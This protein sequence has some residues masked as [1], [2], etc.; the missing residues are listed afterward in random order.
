MAAPLVP[1]RG[2]SARAQPL[3]N[4]EGNMIKRRVRWVAAPS[5]CPLGGM[6]PRPGTPSSE[7]ATIDEQGTGWSTF[8]PH[9]AA[10]WD[11]AQ[12]GTA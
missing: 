7:D 8:P 10:R 3:D 6:Q 2:M 5:P 1:H 12:H 9:T 4:N 11:I